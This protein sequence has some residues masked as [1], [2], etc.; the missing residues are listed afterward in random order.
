ML[1][2]DSPEHFLPLLKE[3]GISLDKPK[4]SDPN[5][6]LTVI[7]KFMETSCTDTAPIDGDGDGL[8]ASFGTYGFDKDE[9]FRV[10]LTRQFMGQEEEDPCIFQVRTSFS[11]PSTPETRAL[12]NDDL[13]SFQ[14]ELDDFFRQAEALPGWV[15]ALNT[16]TAPATTEFSHG[17]CG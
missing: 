8:Y 9:P 3:H 1:F 16:D 7:R 17:C 6:L 12:G 5:T 13:W 14:M 10:S 15:W 4:A 2:H 11:W